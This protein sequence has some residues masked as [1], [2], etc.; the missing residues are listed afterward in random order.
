M[1]RKNLSSG[2]IFLSG[3]LIYLTAGERERSDLKTYICLMKSILEFFRK[4]PGY[5]VFCFMIML[6]LIS[7]GCKKKETITETS[8]KEGIESDTLPDD[9]VSFYDKFHTDSQFQMDHIIFPLEGLPSSIED[10]DTLPTERFFWQRED[11]KK[12]NHFTDPSGQFEHWFEVRGDR[13]IEHWVQMKG[14]NLVMKRRF[15]KMEED[16]YL[17]YYAGMKHNT[18]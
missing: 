14:T 18:N 9:F 5:F 11:W 17:I 16:W 8:E 10:I 15:A 13:I 4:Q 2:S 3:V 1:E 7:E 12:H 6:P